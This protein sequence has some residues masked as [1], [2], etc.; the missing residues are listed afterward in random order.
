[1][2]PQVGISRLRPEAARSVTTN[3][4]ALREDQRLQADDDFTLG[5]VGVSDARLGRTVVADRE[6]AEAS[7]PSP[8]PS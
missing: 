2:R 3:P 4:N 8:C 5:G 1:M 7:D 6:D